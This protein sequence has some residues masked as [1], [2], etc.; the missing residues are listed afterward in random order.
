[1]PIDEEGI[2]QFIT[3]A[4]LGITSL[5]AYWKNNDITK[6]HEQKSRIREKEPFQIKG[7][8]SAKRQTPLPQFDSS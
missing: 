3:L 5:W 4:F 2:Q 6:K 7:S 8:F 1:M